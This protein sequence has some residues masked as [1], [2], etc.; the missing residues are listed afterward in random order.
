MQSKAFQ[1]I[2]GTAVLVLVILAGGWFLLVGNIFDEA[3]EIHEERELVEAN[4]ETLRLRNAALKA[5]YERIDELRAELAELR[6]GIPTRAELDA[7][8]DQIDQIA[9]EHDIVLV[10][11]QFSQ[12]TEVGDSLSTVLAEVAEAEAPEE[13]D[14]PAPA[15]ADAE[16]ADEAGSTPE[17]STPVEPIEGL[18]SIPITFTVQGTYAD[19]R[20]FLADVQQTMDRLYLAQ[21]IALTSLLAAEGGGGLPPT[22]TGDVSLAVA[23]H[24][25]VLTDEHAMPSEEDAEPGDLPAGD[26]SVNP[27]FPVAGVDPDEDEDDDE[28]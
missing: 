23:G 22:Q 15:D 26:D 4:N 20:A 10:G 13:T 9:V 3:S 1:W 8:L 18:F 5:Q 2:A 11:A 24:V 16:D 12:A 27:F 28:E 6:V 19:A 17:A 14:E 21:T 25:F 7:V